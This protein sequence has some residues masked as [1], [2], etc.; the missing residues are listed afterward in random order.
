MAIICPTQ[1]DPD[2]LDRDDFGG[3]EVR[4]NPPHAEYYCNG[5]GWTAVWRRGISGLD[6]IY[7]PEDDT[8]SFEWDF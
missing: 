1:C 7:A 6:I 5:C 3:T 4:N 2:L 8:P